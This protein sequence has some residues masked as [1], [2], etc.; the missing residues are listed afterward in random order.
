MVRRKGG[1]ILA[2]YWHNQGFPNRDRLLKIG[3]PQT[4]QPK[5][6]ELIATTMALRKAKRALQELY[7]TNLGAQ[8]EPL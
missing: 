4:M 2:R 3:I 1:G 5:V 8:S 7:M 6:H